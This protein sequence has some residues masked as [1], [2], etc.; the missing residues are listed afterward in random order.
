MSST[1]TSS[2]PPSP[3]SPL[4]APLHFACIFPDPSAPRLVERCHRSLPTPNKSTSAP[5]DTHSF[6]LQT[7]F[8]LT[9]SNRL[10]PLLSRPTVHLDQFN[11]KRAPARRPTVIVVE[12]TSSV[13]NLCACAQDRIPSALHC[14]GPFAVVRRDTLG[15]AISASPT[16]PL[17]SWPINISI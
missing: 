16:T 15:I 8:A 17:P 11:P 14:D 3:R 12:P 1:T 7:V 13:H 5:L 2:W 6:R 9:R 4:A 10:Q